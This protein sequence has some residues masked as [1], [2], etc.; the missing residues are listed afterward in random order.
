[1][2]VIHP[3]CAGLD[4]HKERWWLACASLLG[5]DVSHEIKT[6][7]TTTSPIAYLLHQCDGVNKGT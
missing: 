1:M 2:E 5:K 3:R 7:E 6:F 4:V